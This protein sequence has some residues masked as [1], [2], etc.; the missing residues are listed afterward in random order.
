[1]VLGDT[2]GTPA[3]GVPVARDGR[4]ADELAA[5][6]VRHHAEMAS[7]HRNLLDVVGEIERHGIFTEHG[8]PSAASWVAAQVS[9]S[10]STAL[11]WVK[12]ARALDELPHLADAYEEGALSFDQL[13]PLTRV[14]TPS[15]DASLAD[16]ATHWS[17][18]QTAEVARSMERSSPTSDA[19]P[20]HRRRLR[21]RWDHDVLH[22]W[23]QFPDADGAVVDA[24]LARLASKAP[25]DP[26]TGTFAPYDERLAD[27]L[28]E[29]CSTIRPGDADADRATVVVHVDA[30]VV[31]GGDGDAELEWVGPVAAETA[32]R[33][34]CDCRWQLVSETPDGRPVGLGRVTRQVPPWMLRHLRRRDGGCRWPGC[35]RTRW[36]HAHHIWFWG[37]GGPT[38]LDNL[39]L[40]CGSHH[41]FVHDSGWT[42]E[43]DPGQ[44]LRFVGPTGHSLRSMARSPD[45]GALRRAGRDPT[46]VVRR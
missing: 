40:L 6:L 3:P 45:T 27:A 14:A 26:S 1:M 42:V 19:P 7:A 12:A 15:N 37:S 43:G 21:T 41:R 8:A 44:E 30:A 22:V 16:R 31:S 46:P 5:A 23:G 32:R 18:A 2:P 11:E 38:E 24:C 35:D 36:L 13:S 20:S 28:L 34:A 17:A 10:V 33:L 39:V 25:A 29:M 4:S 9:V